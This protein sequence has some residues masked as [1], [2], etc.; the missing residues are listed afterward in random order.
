[1]RSSYRGVPRTSPLPR[2][3]SWRSDDATGPVERAQRGHDLRQIDF[4]IATGIVT[5][6]HHPSR[7][8]ARPV[9]PKPPPCRGASSLRKLEERW[10]TILAHAETQRTNAA[11]KQVRRSHRKMRDLRKAGGVRARL[12]SGYGLNRL[13]GPPTKTSRFHPV[14]C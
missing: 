9:R 14:S 7:A 3:N 1:M 12:Q 8:H 6:D 13:P 5:R 2:V 10:T 4:S 11:S